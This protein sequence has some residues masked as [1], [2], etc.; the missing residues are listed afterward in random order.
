MG[1]VSS[2]R[3]TNSTWNPTTGCTKVSPGCDHCYAETIAERFRGGHGWPVGF[4]LQMR[5]AKLNEPVR[6]KEGRRVFVNSMSDVFHKGIPDDYLVEIWDV[7]VSKAPQHTYQILTKRPHV[8]AARISRLG[9]QLA[10][11]IW[12]GVSVENQT[13]ADNRIPVLVEIPAAVRFLSCEPLLG[14]IDL[15]RWINPAD[16][17]YE[18]GGPQGWVPDIRIHWVITGGES[19]ATP[20][21]R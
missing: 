2:I 17:G 6:W 19:G 11:H 18:S 15:G 1:K 20:P 8:A 13:F 10:P 7:M 12:L 9:L 4:D 5:P 14:P 16:A 3:W 21:P